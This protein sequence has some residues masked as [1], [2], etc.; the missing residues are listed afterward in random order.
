MAIMLPLVS[1]LVI[2]YFSDKALEMPR[3]YIP[4]SVISQVR[5]G[6]EVEDTQWH[7]ISDFKLTNQLGEA[8]S[9]DKYRNKIIIADFFFTHCPTIC[10]PLTRNMKRLQESI[11][12]AQRVGDKTNRSVQFISF[13]IDPERDS[14]SRLKAWAD[15]FQ[16]NP[17]QWDLL[18]GD[19]KTIYDLALRD[20]KLGVVDGQGLDTAF[21]HTDHFVLIDSSRNIRG[22]YHGLD[23]ADLA[24]LSTD[25]VLLTLEKSPNRKNGLASILKGTSLIFL[26]AALGIGLFLIIFKKKK[27]A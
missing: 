18:T 3:R 27:H 20:M 7:K 17:E 26:I 1:F 25:L 15:R 11:T 22:Y 19:K 12:N 23:S 8:V 24:R 5:N 16:I 14:V 10:P 6:K 21:I 13:S 4:D 9:L 2:R